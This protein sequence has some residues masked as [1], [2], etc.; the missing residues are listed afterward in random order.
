MLI[1]SLVRMLAFLIFFFYSPLV[2]G[3]L[4]HV[5]ALKF[6]QENPWEWSSSLQ[7]IFFSEQPFYRNYSTLDSHTKTVISHVFAYLSR[8]CRKPWQDLL[9]WVFF[10]WLNLCLW[11]SLWNGHFFLSPS[12]HWL[13]LKN[14]LQQPPLYH[15]HFLLSPRWPLLR[16]SIVFHFLDKCMLLALMVD[17]FLNDRVKEVVAVVLETLVSK[18]KR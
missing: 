15:G 6:F 5:N 2:L 16:G 14:S 13:L 12:I 1:K 18:E 3:L 4:V 11:P 7:I 17:T 9:R 10:L 8:W